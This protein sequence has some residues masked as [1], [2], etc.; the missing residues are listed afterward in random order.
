MKPSVAL[1]GWV[2]RFGV[3]TGWTVIGYLPQAGGFCFRDTT[4]LA[5]IVSID[6]CGKSGEWVHVSVSR[7][8]RLPSWGDLA[9]VKS[10]FIGDDREAIQFLP[11]RSEWVNLHEHCLHMWSRLDG[12]LAVPDMEGAK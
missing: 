3:R 9:R 7:K 8:A 11:S 1:A 5:V 10:D 4:G 12:S 2:N 6:E